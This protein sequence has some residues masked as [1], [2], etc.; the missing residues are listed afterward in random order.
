[1]ATSATETA[2]Q[3][4]G[5]RVFLESVIENNREPSFAEMRKVYDGYNMEWKETYKKQAAA[6]KTYIGSRKGY[7]YSRDTGIMPYIEEIAKKDCGVSVK[8]RWD[9]MDIVMVKR[10]MKRVVEG[11]IREITNLGGM[12]KDANLLILNSYMRE[13]LRDK[14]LIGIS[15]KAIKATKKNASVELANM[16]GDK[17]ARVNITPIDRSVKCT[18]TLGKK[19]NYL[20]DTGELGFDLET[21]TGAK[22]HGQSRNFQY[23]KE[24][25][26][27]Q[28]DLTPKGRDAGAK[29]GKVSSVA[30][31]EFL[32]KQGLQRPP[33]AARHPHIP[34]VGGINGGNRWE[35]NDKEYWIDLYKELERSSFKIDFGEVAVYE[36]GQRIGEGFEQV[37]DKSIDYETRAADRSS[38]G[39]FS[40][41]LISMEW[42][43]IWSELAKKGKLEDWGRVLYYGA[44]KEFSSRNGPFLKIF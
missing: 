37:L 16:Q 20:F 25:N 23:S 38:A 6:I 1:M 36:N 28:T 32:N 31:D 8:D 2:K 3:E 10:S 14:V 13:A 44:K 24:R 43:K 17:A 33:S 4:N 29:L 42:A 11:T 40:S 18:L 26:V 27:I 34:P 7:D 39:R 15:L 19:A 35:K 5:S 12:T 9:P 41:K 21:E 22:I 30:L